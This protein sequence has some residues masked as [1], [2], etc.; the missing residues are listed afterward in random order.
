MT[1]LKG[2]HIIKEIEGEEEYE[3]SRLG[4]GS[5]GITYR[6]YQNETD[7]TTTLTE[8]GTQLRWRQETISNGSFELHRLRVSW[9]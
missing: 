7:N 8:H 3:E 1:L 5:I 2:K 4:P 6:Y 9:R